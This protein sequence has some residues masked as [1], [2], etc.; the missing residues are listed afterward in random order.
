MPTINAVGPNGQ[1]TS[2]NFEYINESKRIYTIKDE[3]WQSWNVETALYPDRL[4]KQ[5]KGF[6]KDLKVI[7]SRAYFNFLRNNVF[8][9]NHT[10]ELNALTHSPIFFS[11]EEGNLSANNFTEMFYFRTLLQFSVT[12]DEESNLTYSPIEETEISFFPLFTDEISVISTESLIER[13]TGEDSP[14]PDEEKQE[15]KQF[16]E[17]MV[18]NATVSS[19][20]MF[21][22][23]TILDV[24]PCVDK[25]T[26][27]HQ[28]YF[29]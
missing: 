29:S 10:Y 5:G 24:I 20:Q 25:I 15:T 26:Y 8:D 14:L 27:G 6:A 4:Q 22:N 17:E 9:P 18:I 13:L 7:E 28:R 21:L 3:N 19:R 16:I 12:T 2:M 23:K 11:D 1:Q